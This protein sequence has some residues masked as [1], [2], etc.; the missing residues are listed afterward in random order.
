MVN[1]AVLHF[2]ASTCCLGSE[3]NLH[4]HGHGHGGHSG[5]KHADEEKGASK[6]TEKNGGIAAKKG[7]CEKSS[8]LCAIE[9]V[10]RLLCCR[11]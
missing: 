4:H 1:G 5:H 7:N 10:S 9:I 11:F 8:V 2:G 6:K 3:L